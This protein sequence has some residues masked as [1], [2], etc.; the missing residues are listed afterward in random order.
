MLVSHGRLLREFSQPPRK[1]S[2]GIDVQSD[3]CDE[4]TGLL[5]IG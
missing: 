2:R 5:A 4:E 3:K 1:S